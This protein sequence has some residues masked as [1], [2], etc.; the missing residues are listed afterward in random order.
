MKHP[1]K[2]ALLDRDTAVEYYDERFSHGYMAQWP[3][4]KRKRLSEIIRAM[5]LPPQGEALD[6][7]CGSGA[8]TDIVSQAL[9]PQWKV[10]GS[11]ISNVAVE[12][13]RRRFPQHTFFVAGDEAMAGRQ[14]DFLFSHHV[15][16]HVHDVHETAQEMNR[17]LKPA[18][19]MLHVMPCGN[20]GS[21]EHSIC[22]LKTNGINP[23]MG[24]CF[25]HEDPGHLRRLTTEQL[26]TLMVDIGF[27][28]AAEYYAN[29]HAG[30]IEYLTRHPRRVS[31]FADPANAVDT[32]AQ[33]T[34]LRLR[35][36]LTAVTWARR[37]AL[38]VE[39]V[40]RRATWKPKDIAYLFVGIPAYIPSKLVNTYWEWAARRE[41]DT[42]HTQRN[43]SEMFI[44]FTRREA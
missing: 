30:A 5:N 35:R 24:H 19:A 15:L 9:P 18:A 44:V 40:L 38:V 10:Y 7:G 14:F 25:F 27:T 39:S 6:F 1:D 32:T 12:N 34:I 29:Q 11:D 43:G 21:L 26:E 31:Q 28:L 23:D 3:A 20:P 42:Q 4:T 17:L 2:Q 16:E 22:L 13:A 33:R 36:W 8:L 41:W 37:P